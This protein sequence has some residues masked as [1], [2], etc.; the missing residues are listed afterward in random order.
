MTFEF[1][2][3]KTSLRKSISIKRKYKILVI[4][5]KNN[6]FGNEVS[7]N[8][9]YVILSNERTKEDIIKYIKLLSKLFIYI[10]QSYKFF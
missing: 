1:K 6:C 2:V 10:M 5:L 4:Y 3:S 8:D 7:I 9:T